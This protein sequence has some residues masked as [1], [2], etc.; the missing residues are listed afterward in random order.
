MTRRRC[1]T[2]DNGVRTMTLRYKNGEKT[3]RV[4]EGIPIVTVKP[5]ERSLLVPRDAAAAYLLQVS[6]SPVMRLNTG[7]RAVWSRRS[8]TK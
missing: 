8:A 4:P 2:A 6:R 5:G 1:N 7:A 3:I